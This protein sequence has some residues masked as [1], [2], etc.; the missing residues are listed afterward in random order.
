MHTTP[1]F[2]ILGAP[3][4]GTTIVSKYLSSHPEVF[5]SIPKEPG[6]FDRDLRYSSPQHCPYSSLEDYLTIYDSVDKSRHKVVGESSVFMLYSKSALDQILSI[7]IN[8]K[9]LIMLRN[10]YTAAPSMHTQ[11]LKC[12]GDDREPMLSFEDAWNDLERRATI[13]VL[14]NTNYLKFKYDYLFT[15][16]KHIERVVALTNSDQ[17]LYIKYEDFCEDNEKEMTK[18]YNFLE[19]SASHNAPK[20]ILNSA[21]VARNN[22][23]SR[24]IFKVANFS[25]SFKLLRFLRGRRYTLLF[26]QKKPSVSPI[27]VDL[28]NRMYSVFQSD[29]QKVQYLT[30]LDLSSWC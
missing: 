3:K 26:T 24:F 20:M 5:M 23:L 19:I 16:S 1:N 18:I 21:T 17:V 7:N 4:C 8:S 25:R 11:N 13:N 30:G 15:Y 22:I 9:F 12:L 2:F 14:D 10:P 27:D 6:Y 29:I 28:K